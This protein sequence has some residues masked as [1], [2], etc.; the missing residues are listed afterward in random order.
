[1]CLWQQAA[2][3]HPDPIAFQVAAALANLSTINLLQ[4]AGTVGRK[5][6]LGRFQQAASECVL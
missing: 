5:D 1:M 4:A 3:A 6:Y 2:V